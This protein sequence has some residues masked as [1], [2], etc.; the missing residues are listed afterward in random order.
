M[1]A[2]EQQ[3]ECVALRLFEHVQ[4][5]GT[6]GD[7]EGAR[8]S[9]NVHE[10]QERGHDPAENHDQHRELLVHV[11]EQP[12]ERHRE[13]DQD[14]CANQIGDHSEAKEPLVCEDVVRGRGRVPGDEELFGDVDEPEWT[15]ENE[16]QVPESCDAPRIAGCGHGAPFVYGTR[17]G[18]AL[19]RTAER[20]PL[21][22][23]ARRMGAKKSLLDRS[24][25][26]LQCHQLLSVGASGFEP[27]TS[28]SR[29]RRANRAAPR[30]EFPEK[31]S[32]RGDKHTANSRYA[33]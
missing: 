10:V 32:N 11:L 8:V 30:P 6:L 21:F 27:P 3:N 17:W 5:I 22:H 7:H 31:C 12:V 14:H 33:R 13:A 1:L 15:E 25:K 19:A 23:F 18:G 16:G 26:R 20:N 24:S 9:R 28:W 2:E 4:K 29:T